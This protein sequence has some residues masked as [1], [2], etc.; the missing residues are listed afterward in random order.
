MP[1]PFCGGNAAPATV[2]CSP[3]C[4]KAQGWTQE[5]FHYV[6]CVECG[7]NNKSL[8]GFDT[9]EKAAER[10]NKRTGC[11]DESDGERLTL[12][13]EALTDWRAGKLID[14]AALFAIEFAAVPARALTEAERQLGFEIAGLCERLATVDPI[15]EEASKR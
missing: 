14:E 15:R 11:R 4:A 3:G 7:S 10:W 12:V 5:T 13:R 1:C 9:P 6:N 8:V 2:T